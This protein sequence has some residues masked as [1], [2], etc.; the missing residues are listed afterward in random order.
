M[1]N[2]KIAENTTLILPVHSQLDQFARK[3]GGQE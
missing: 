1:D 2:L 3:G